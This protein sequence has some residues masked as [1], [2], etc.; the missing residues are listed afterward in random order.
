MGFVTSSNLHTELDIVSVCESGNWGAEI[1][2]AKEQMWFLLQLIKY[3][4]SAFFP[5]NRFFSLILTTCYSNTRNNKDCRLLAKTLIKLS[6]EYTENSLVPTS[7]NW[8]AQ[9]L[10]IQQSH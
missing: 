6:I 8:F 5:V 9:S 7:H 2:F 10:I 4:R 1:R 3:D